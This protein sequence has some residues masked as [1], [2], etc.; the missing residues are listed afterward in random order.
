MGVTEEVATFIADF[1][2]KDIP[3]KGIEQARFS[4]MDSLG[5]ALVASAGPVGGIM[6]D[7]VKEMGGAPQARLVGSGVKTSVYN[8][9]LA[10]GTLAH[11]EDYD[12]MSKFGEKGASFGHFGV[13]LT[14]TVLALGEKLGLSGKKILEA[15]VIGFEI[16]YRLRLALGDVQSKGIHKTSVYGALSAAGASA[17]LLGLTVLQTRRAIGIASSL[18]SGIVQNFGTY[19]KGLHAG[20][21][22]CS[23]IMAAVLAKKEFTGDPE[24]LEA[25][26]G[27]AHVFGQN[28]S[29]IRLMSQNIGRPLAISEYGVTIKP[30]PCCGGNHAPLTAIFR[31]IEQND[32]KPEQVSSI[33]VATASKPPGPLIRSNPQNGFEGKFSLQYNMAAA[34]IDHKVDLNTFTNEKLSRPEMQQL[35]RKVSVVWNP[36][37]A[38]ESQKSKS[39][40]RYVLVTVKLN[41]GRVLS[42][43]QYSHLARQLYGEEVYAKYRE[44]AKF[45]GIGAKTVERSV[46]LLA[47][48]ENVNDVTQLID[49]VVRP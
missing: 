12:D 45:S 39:E 41:D 5:T 29:D 46:E 40:P 11:A 33:E 20:R 36:V 42:E 26:H 14:P 2:F 34:L 4:I 47:G 24:V 25:A 37:F 7:Y 35:I 18:P 3:P 1:D 6:N 28:P 13:V 43:R 27:I 30:W 38:E 8:A 17:K 9:A 32:I 48:L 23:G 31:L 22:A 49:T 10:N 44:N 16:A 15:Y 19:T 21:T